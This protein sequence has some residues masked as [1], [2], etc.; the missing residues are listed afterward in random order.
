MIRQSVTNLVTRL[1]NLLLDGDRENKS[2]STGAGYLYSPLL[3]RVPDVG[4]EKYRKNNKR[5]NRYLFFQEK[6]LRKFLER[7]EK[8]KVAQIWMLMLKNSLTYQILLYHKTDKSW[9]WKKDGNSVIKELDHIISKLRSWDIRFSLNRFYVIKNKQDPTR[10]GIKYEGELLEG[11]KLRPIGCADK[12]TTMVSRSMTELITFLVEPERN[13]TQHGYRQSM[14]TYSAISSLV[15][16]YQNNQWAHVLEIDYKSFFN[17]VNLDA[18]LQ[19]LNDVPNLKNQLKHWLLTP[20]YTMS[21]LEEESELSLLQESFSTSEEKW[22][23]F[24][25]KRIFRHKSQRKNKKITLIERKGLPQGLSLSPLLSTLSIE[26]LGWDPNLSKHL[27][28][29]MY[30]DD[31]VLMFNDPAYVSDYFERI[32]NSGVKL[33]ETKSKLVD[34]NE[35]F[36]FLGVYVKLSTGEVKYKD[37]VKSVHDKEFDKWLMTVAS[38]YGKEPKLWTWDIHPNAIIKK[39]TLWNY[40]HPWVTE[41]YREYKKY[42]L[43]FLWLEITNP[44]VFKNLVHDNM[45]WHSI[46][47]NNSMDPIT[48]EKQKIWYYWLLFRESR[49]G[50]IYAWDKLTM[51]L[52]MD[53]ISK[54]KYTIK[55]IYNKYWLGNYYSVMYSSSYCLSYLYGISKG[56]SVKK[57]SPLKIPNSENQSFKND[58]WIRPNIIGLWLSQ[59]RDHTPEVKKY[60]KD[61]SRYLDSQIF[62]NRYKNTME[63]YGNSAELLKYQC[64]KLGADPNKHIKDNQKQR[65]FI[66]SLKNEIKKEST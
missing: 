30:A 5:A 2:Y 13:N 66:K 9:Y 60:L 44:N 10:Q 48:S 15:K 63:Y 34:P 57:K 35:W 23:A 18:S 17:T 53:L 61:E 29:T 20:K 24:L 12:L 1:K 31:G 33:E 8:N 16:S 47:N 37:H 25:K 6:R 43:R 40:L 36:K 59:M 3:G 50:V 22:W 65:E 7:N 38:K 11:E 64:R 45:L 39:F 28:I 4:L 21:S 14:G 56:L 55:S 42:P 58:K 52:D 26:K 27:D 41:Q 54:I 46:R 62:I 32:S 49:H 51:P 19:W